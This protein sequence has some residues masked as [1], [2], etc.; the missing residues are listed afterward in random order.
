[1]GFVAASTSAKRSRTTRSTSPGLTIVSAALIDSVVVPKVS[2]S[3][4]IS[5]ISG[6]TVWFTEF[7]WAVT[8]PPAQDYGYAACNTEQNQADFI[9]RAFQ[10]VRA[11]TPYVTH[12]IVWKLNFQQIVPQTDEKW[13]F[14]ILRSDLS[15]RPAYTALKNMAKP[16]PAAGPAG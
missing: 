4:P 5:R 14:G 8:D 6:K 7:G 1:M 13:A 11:E 15:P 16:Q 2:T 10:K 12:L 9:V 3:N